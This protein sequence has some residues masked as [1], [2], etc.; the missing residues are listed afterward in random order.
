MAMLI[1]LHLRTRRME[2]SLQEFK[3]TETPL[4]RQLIINSTTDAQ[5]LAHRYC[6]EKKHVG[7][8]KLFMSDPFLKEIFDKKG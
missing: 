4:T 1:K 5:A 2:L 3:N 7:Y 8:H 6:R